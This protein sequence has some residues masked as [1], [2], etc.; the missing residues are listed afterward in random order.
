MSQGEWFTTYLQYENLKELLNVILY[1]SQSFMT[2]TPILYHINYNSKEIL[3]VHTGIVG[4]VVAHYHV[5][6]LNPP[7]KYIELN[8]ITSDFKFVEKNGNNPQSIYIPIVKL[9]KSTLVFPIDS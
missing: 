5:L 4:G 7:T 9:I 3:F 2:I 1:T 8:K 6:E